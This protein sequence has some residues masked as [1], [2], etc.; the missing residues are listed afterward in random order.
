[1][2]L[3]EARVELCNDKLSDFFHGHLF[4]IGSLA[5][6]IGH[7]EGNFVELLILNHLTS[8]AK[9]M[10]ADL[11]LVDVGLS[12][13]TTFFDCKNQLL[14][15]DSHATRNLK[16]PDS[17]GVVRVP[18]VANKLL[19]ILIVKLDL[20]R[21]VSSSSKRLSHGN[22]NLNHVIGYLFVDLSNLELL[23]FLTNGRYRS[24]RILFSGVE[25]VHLLFEGSN[26]LN[27]L[28]S[29]LF[30]GIFLLWVL[31]LLE[32][33]DAL[34]SL[35]L[36]LIDLLFQ[37]PRYVVKLPISCC[38]ILTKHYLRAQHRNQVTLVHSSSQL[39]VGHDSFQFL[40]VVQHSH[41]LLLVSHDFHEVAGCIHVLELPLLES[42]VHT[43]I[44][45]DLLYQFGLLKVHINI[46]LFILNHL[47]RL[48]NFL[49]SN[50]RL[51]RS[52]FRLWLR[53]TLLNLLSCHCSH[54]LFAILNLSHG[55]LESRLDDGQVL[56][57]ETILIG[58][59][60][61][62]HFPLCI[63][64]HLIKVALHRHELVANVALD[65]VF[66]VLER[67]DSKVE[68]VPQNVVFN[69]FE[70]ILVPLPLVFTCTDTVEFLNTVVRL[71]QLD[72]ALAV[73]TSGLGF[74]YF[75]LTGKLLLCD[76]MFL[77]MSLQL[78]V[79]HFAFS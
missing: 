12:E 6:S 38:L 29:P 42:F 34:L 18:V 20:D 62:G 57:V 58:L 41:R 7:I 36:Q 68:L 24:P 28:L 64:L 26:H 54:L 11:I 52:V 53:L 33:I 4:L 49:L 2:I 5:H 67:L 60:V 48:H 71:I 8:V 79:F 15:L 43:L 40:R 16:L 32:A 63:S 69:H 46:I 61:V 76:S 45:A 77:H 25:L 35:T 31:N 73:G 72:Q 14:V 37:V 30:Q 1:M 22:I 47:S 44:V 56:L 21:L 78:S 55:F 59:L 23:D 17:I 70:Q 19:T 66:V 74:L 10:Q 9:S 13:E 3:Y 65:A 51:H 50:L 75:W 27:E 39:Q